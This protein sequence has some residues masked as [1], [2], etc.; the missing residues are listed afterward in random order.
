MFIIY[1]KTR[2]CD[3]DAGMNDKGLFLLFRASASI[4]SLTVKKKFN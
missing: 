2:V 1:T 4:P 3:D